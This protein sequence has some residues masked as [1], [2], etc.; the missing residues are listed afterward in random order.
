MKPKGLKKKTS[1][2]KIDNLILQGFL[3]VFVCCVVVNFIQQHNNYIALIK[4]QADIS[5]LIAAEEELQLSFEE[6]KEY[7]NSDQYIEEMARLQLGM[8]KPNEVLFINRS[9]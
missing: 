9:Q 6:K 7:A 4:E 8:I 2:K 3:F 5:S 1:V